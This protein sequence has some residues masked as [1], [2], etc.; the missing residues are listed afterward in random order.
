M[1]HVL[2]AIRYDYRNKIYLYY[3]GRNV[4]YL[5]YKCSHAYSHRDYC[6]NVVS[7]ED[8]VPGMSYVTVNLQII[9]QY[10]RESN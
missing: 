6:H 4:R 9:S 1:E 10:N 7:V 8:V 5:F 2:R 3:T